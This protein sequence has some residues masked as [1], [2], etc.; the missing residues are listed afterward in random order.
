[1]KKKIFIVMTLV[2]VLITGTSNDANA[3]IIQNGG[4][5]A[6]Y[7]FYAERYAPSRTI[8][9]TFVNGFIFNGQLLQHT[10]DSSDQYDVGGHMRTAINYWEKPVSNYTYSPCSQRQVID[11]GYTSNA[12]TARI[13]FIYLPKVTNLTYPGS[14]YKKDYEIKYL[15]KYKR[16]VASPNSSNWDYVEIYLYKSFNDLPS[17]GVNGKRAVLSQLIGKAIGLET[18]YQSNGF[19]NV[20]RS[21]SIMST[22]ADRV[23]L[24]NK[25]YKAAYR[26]SCRDFKQIDAIYK[27]DLN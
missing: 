4:A 5:H 18:L 20:A 23:N 16:T 25:G 10:P 11:F 8:T 13:K 24:K 1:M 2:F 21:E 9:Y 7:K 26:P 19:S 3:L 15:D 22:T 14:T 12:D 17:Y 6:N 27:F